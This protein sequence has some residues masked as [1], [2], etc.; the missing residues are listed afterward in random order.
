MCARFIRHVF[1]YPQT[2]INPVS[3]SVKSAVVRPSHFFFFYSTYQRKAYR[4]Y[5]PLSQPHRIRIQQY[6]P[7]SLSRLPLPLP[8][9][10]FEVK[11]P[12]CF[13]CL[14]PSSLLNELHA[15]FES[16]LR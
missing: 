4:V 14:R 5:Y 15:L 3:P 8:P 12:C 7:P 13:L 16:Y 2:G 11:V 9:L 1:N 10:P 6:P